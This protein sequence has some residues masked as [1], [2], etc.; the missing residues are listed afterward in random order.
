MTGPLREKLLE[1]EVLEALNKLGS[2]PREVAETLVNKGIQLRCRKPGHA[3]SRNCPVAVYLSQE[4][5]MVA[6]VG[7]EVC[8]LLPEGRK[9]WGD[10]KEVV[11]KTPRAVRGFISE[12]DGLNKD[13]GKEVPIKL[14]RTWQ[15]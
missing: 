12:F 2:T 11:I 14:F 15:L 9:T 1:A 3:R 5:N 8:Y 13:T 4:F 7:Q 6:S 10:G